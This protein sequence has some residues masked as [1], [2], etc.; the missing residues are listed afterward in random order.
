MDQGRATARRVG[1]SLLLALTVLGCDQGLSSDYTVAVVNR[2]PHE[3]HFSVL[4]DQTWY[5]AVA[6][7]KPNQMDVVL[8]SSILPPGGCT[9]GGM[10]AL[11]EDG[12][13]VS[14]HDAPLC[15][16]DRWVIDPS[17]PSPSGSGP[18]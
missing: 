1:L 4:L 7:V 18:G 13:E 15:A 8:P 14:R 6:R 11:A 17:G 9:K 2:T 16:G 10:I 3:L 5:A 12:Q